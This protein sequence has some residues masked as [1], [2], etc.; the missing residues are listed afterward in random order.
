M[1][2]VCVLAG[3]TLLF[4]LVWITGANM[5]NI[6]V[7][8]PVQNQCNYTGQDCINDCSGV[9]AGIWQHCH[10]CSGFLYC[11]DEIFYPCAPETYFHQLSPG[12]G[13]CASVSLTCR[14]C[15]IPPK[16]ENTGPRCHNL[17]L[18]ACE[19]LSNGNYQLCNNCTSY[20]VCDAGSTKVVHCS[21]GLYY[22]DRLDHKGCI[23][24]SHTCVE[25][26]TWLWCNATGLQCI[27]DCTGLENG[28]YQSCDNCWEYTRCFNQNPITSYCLGGYF[29]DDNSQGCIE[30][31]STCFHCDDKNIC[32][33]TGEGCELR[34]A[35]LDDGYYQTCRRCDTYIG[36]KDG[37]T[38]F[39]ECRDGY[40]WDN[41]VFACVPIAS[42]TCTECATM[43]PPATTA[44]SIDG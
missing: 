30:D 19:F 34:C 13:T 22:D 43:P 6:P 24:E 16:C 35:N 32:D 8:E 11:P 15:Y 40:V 17:T 33:Y 28:Q 21:P 4:G 39:Y 12:D 1:K 25:C 7:L 37:L 44:I 23:A 36:C 27:N 41:L 10:N 29:W 3:I 9:A 18:G 38:T 20:L 14:E 31:S 26:F 5:V 42:R 2:T